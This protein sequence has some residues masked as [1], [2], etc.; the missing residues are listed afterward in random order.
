MGYNGVL[1]FSFDQWMHVKFLVKGLQAELYLDNMDE[2]VAFIRELKMA[3]R[4]GAVGI[5]SGLGAAHFANFSYLSTSDVV[6]KTKDDGYKPSTPAN[7]VMKWLVSTPFKEDKLK[8]MDQ[9]DM[10]L[11]E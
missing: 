11:D 8:D 10:K 6:L 9:L 1:N 4:A 7:T 3:G 5:T 2:P